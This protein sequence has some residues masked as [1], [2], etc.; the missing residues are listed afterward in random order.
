VL[1]QFSTELSHSK[2][3]CKIVDRINSRHA[4][5][6]QNSVREKSRNKDQKDKKRRN[7]AMRL[8][9]YLP[10]CHGMTFFAAKTKPTRA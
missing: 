5:E 1:V 7:Y 6:T 9:Q 10:P 2:Q 4:V 8:P 3:L